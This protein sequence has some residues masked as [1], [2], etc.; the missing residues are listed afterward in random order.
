VIRNWG[1]L[2]E[3]AAKNGVTT[4]TPIWIGEVVAE[5]GIEY[6]SRVRKFD[7]EVSMETEEMGIALP[8]DHPRRHFETG[9]VFY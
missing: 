8:K 9:M 1:E 5:G 6:L 7:A 4:S 3:F 2:L